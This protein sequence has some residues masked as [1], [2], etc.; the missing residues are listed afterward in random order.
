MEAF[1]HEGCSKWRSLMVPG[2]HRLSEEESE[3]V[4]IRIRSAMM[5]PFPVFVTSPFPANEK[6]GEIIFGENKVF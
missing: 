3:T 2:L 5:T 1:Q 4:S 6:G